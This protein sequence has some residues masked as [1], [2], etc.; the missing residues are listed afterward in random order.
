MDDSK[1]PPINDEDEVCA[2]CGK[3]AVDDVKLKKCACNLVK[4]CS[5]D[6]QKNHRPQHKMACKKRA[7][8]IRDDRLFSQPDEG[9]YGECPIC[10]LP[11][12]LDEDK[13]RLNSCCCQRICGGCSYANKLREEEQ[14]LEH[15]CPYCREPVPKT[16]EEV[17]K[18]YMNR[19]KANDPMAIFQMGNKCRQEGDYEEAFQYYAKAAGLGDIEAHYNLSVSYHLGK[20]VEKNEK[21]ELHHLEIAAIGGHPEARHNLGCYEGRNGRHERAMQHFIIA[22]KLGDDRA[23][24]A[25]KRGFALGFVS[26]EEYAS[27]L[28]G[29]QAAIDATKSEQR[30]EAYA[31]FKL[32]GL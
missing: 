15:K 25:L 10:C 29:H 30:E 9:H 6:C 8:E 7:A 11:L 18:N 3:A 27:A 14:G 2:N 5:V 23:L 19:A 21:K 16:H 17:E 26:K 31:F 13:S 32:T 4:Y 12:P 28:R 22:A 24:E 1:E 20:G